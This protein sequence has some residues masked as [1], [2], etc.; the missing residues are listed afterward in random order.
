MKLLDFINKKKWNEVIK[1]IKNINDSILNGNS[2]IHYAGLQNDLNLF[3]ILVKKKAKLNKTNDNGQNIAHIT[4]E[5]GYYNLL[6]KIIDTD[7]NILYNKDYKLNTTFYYL[8]DNLEILKYIF[9]K[10]KKIDYKYL[11]NQIN[12]NGYTPLTKVID[13]GLYKIIKFFMK[14]KDI[15]FNTPFENL[16]IFTLIE[17]DLFK[18]KEK[19]ELLNVLK[20]FLLK[21]VL[22]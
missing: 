20:I 6:K 10:Y 3:N 1:I 16:P 14:N 15:D 21:L 9:N 7:P 12:I 8:S 19:I 17:S 22:V 4:A 13:K 5:H 11:L 18:T 2:L